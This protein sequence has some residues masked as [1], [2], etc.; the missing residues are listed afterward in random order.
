M[1]WALFVDSSNSVSFDPEFDFKQPDEKIQSQH[2]TKSGALFQ[3]RW[4]EFNN[5]N[6]TMM[7]VN[8]ADALAINLWWR[9]NTQLLF[10]DENTT[11]VSSVIIM[12]KK[13]PLSERIKPYSDQFRGQIKLGTY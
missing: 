2:R 7:Y 10:M 3:Y 11:A 4:G 6:F 9:N 12:N 5:F 13:M 1:T 8:S